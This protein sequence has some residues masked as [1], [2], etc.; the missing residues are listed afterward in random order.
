MI[1]EQSNVF[2]VQLTMIAEQSTNNAEQLTT[3]GC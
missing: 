2:A 3:Y 1:T